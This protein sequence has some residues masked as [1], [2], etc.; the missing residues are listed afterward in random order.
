M[1]T[2]STEWARHPRTDENACPLFPLFRK[3]QA[4]IS[5]RLGSS[6][7]RHLARPVKRGFPLRKIPA[8]SKSTS[9]AIL[10]VSRS[11]KGAVS[12]LTPDFADIALLKTSVVVLP[13]GESTP[14][15]VMATLLMLIWLRRCRAVR[16]RAVDHVDNILNSVY[17]HFAL[18]DLYFEFILKRKQELDLIE[19]VN[20]EAFQRRFRR[21]QV[22]VQVELVDE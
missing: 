11:A 16:R 4:R 9:A 14:S 21:K 1:L 18:G 10:A 19:R 5:H 15:P 12:L 8:I 22:S 6:S 20:A 13:K 3:E 2:S 7:H 17:F